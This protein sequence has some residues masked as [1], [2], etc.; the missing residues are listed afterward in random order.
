MFSAVTRS[1]SPHLEYN[2]GALG[3]VHLY[4]RIWQRSIYAVVSNHVHVC[5]SYNACFVLLAVPLQPPLAVCS[6]V[7]ATLW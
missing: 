4:A 2:K 3:C 5:M 1:N 6:R 7:L